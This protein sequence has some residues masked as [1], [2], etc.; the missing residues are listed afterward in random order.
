MKDNR[1]ENR[2]ASALQKT[3]PNDVQ[4]VLSR[5]HERKGTGITVMTKSH[6]RRWIGAIAACLALLLLGTGALLALRQ[7]DAVASVISLDV[8]PSI[9]LKVDSRERVI[10]CTPL[11]DDAKA[12]LADMDGGKDLKN[13]KL[14]VAVN[15]VVGSL[16]RSGYLTR[17]SSALMISVEDT[18]MTRAE[19]LRRELNA[20]VD[21]ILQSGE[22]KAAVLTQTVTQDETLE[23]LAEQNHISTGK[24]ALVS[25]IRE[26]NPALSFEALAKLSVGELKDLQ[27]TG[28]A[29][30]PIGLQKA[31]ELA[32]AA[33]AKASSAK[34]LSCE[35]DAELDDTPPHYEVELK[36]ENGEEYE[37]KLDAFTGAILSVKQD[38]DDDTPV[39]RPSAT[40]PAAKPSG[41]TTAA[42]KVTKPADIGYAGALAAALKRAGLTEAQVRETE[43]EPDFED[44]RAVYEVEFVSGENEYEITVDAATG[45]I[46]DYEVDRD[47]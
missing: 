40:T 1:M 47:D 46:L 2:L 30:L 43:I 12:V 25:R 6:N 14:D 8:N 4:G 35:T 20:A 42:T 32:K 26:K 22:S 21:A 36:N 15:A 9:E 17:L 5:C 34:L 3:A 24:A 44:G 28:A 16:L 33:Y 18:D 31:E 39:S 27:K 11:N 37:Y 10:A 23:K 7:T 13:A 38:I 19:K 41:S 29:A 45:K